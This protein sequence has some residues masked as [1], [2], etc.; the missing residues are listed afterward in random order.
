MPTMSSREPGAAVGGPV[1]YAIFRLAR[2]HRMLAGRLLREVGLH[3]GQELLMMHLWEVGPQRQ[4]DLAAEFDT[5]SA[6]M[7]RTVQRLERAGYV[8][9]VPDPADG[10]ATLV[11][12]TAASLR[13]RREVER[14]WERLEAMT[15]DG[16]TAEAQK[17]A[18]SSICRLEDNLLAA[19]QD[20]P[21]AG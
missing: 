10:R 11:E 15:V 1:S 14:V 7:T 18:L 13:L 17:R 21:P 6:S 3:T 8:R 12:P 19:E 20:P 5:D 2:V 9:R 4:S 16:M